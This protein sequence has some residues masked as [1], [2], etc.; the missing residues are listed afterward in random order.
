MNWKD[1]KEVPSYVLLAFGAGLFI[2]GGL[3][4]AVLVLLIEKG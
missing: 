4:M 3:G 2:G 1:W